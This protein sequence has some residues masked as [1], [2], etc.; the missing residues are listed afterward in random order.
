MINDHALEVHDLLLNFQRKR[1]LIARSRGI[2]AQVAGAS[3]GFNEETVLNTLNTRGPLNILQLA[4]AVGVERSWMSRIVSGLTDAKLVRASVDDSDR[5]SRRIEPTP[6]GLNELKRLDEQ[7]AVIMQAMLSSLSANEQN[8]LARLLTKLADGSG[9]PEFTPRPGTNL[10]H[11][12]A[13]RLSIAAGVFSD[14]VLGSSLSIT[15]VQVLYALE[16]HSDDGL[17]VS[18]LDEYLPFDMSTISRTIS[19]FEKKG[20]VH[21][22]QS[23]EDKRS[24][25]LQLS[26]AG[27]RQLKEYRD[28]ATQGFSRFLTHFVKSETTELTMLL[29][30]VVSSI[31][32]AART[33]RV[34]SVELHSI[35]ATDF[36][37]N[38]LD[39]IRQLTVSRDLTRYSGKGSLFALYQGGQP[40]GVVII[41]GDSRKPDENEVLLVATGV[42]GRE[43]AAL[44]RKASRTQRLGGN[45]RKT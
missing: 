26:S 14:D 32:S 30:R 35:K 15:H 28:H 44:L 4:D 39:A 36:Q 11:L 24:Y 25:T 33:P 37:G 21:K 19:G 42:S 23:A 9:A 6:H 41:E 13:H 22:K 31:P 16:E 38:L 1:R 7:T 27:E 18:L 8:R 10:T 17:R 3:L 5:R 40:C 45:S 2:Q 29:K 34:G 43:A 20:L 12:A